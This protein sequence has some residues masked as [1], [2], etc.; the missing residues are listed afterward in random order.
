MAK[1]TG[2]FRRWHSDR[3]TSMEATNRVLAPLLGSALVLGLVAC[4]GKQTRNQAPPPAPVQAA[5]QAPKPAEVD[6]PDLSTAA[7][8]LAGF[9]RTPVANARGRKPDDPLNDYLAYLLSSKA[10]AP[11]AAFK[12]LDQDPDLHEVALKV[13]GILKTGQAKEAKDAQIRDLV[14]A[15]TRKRSRDQG[16]ELAQ[17]IAAAALAKAPRNTWV[18][19]PFKVDV[20]WVDAK[21]LLWVGLDDA[22]HRWG[23]SAPCKA[24][25]DSPD[26]DAL[27]RAIVNQSGEFMDTVSQIFLENLWVTTDY[28]TADPINQLKKSKGL[29]L[30]FMNFNGFWKA[31]RVALLNAATQEVVLEITKDNLAPPQRAGKAAVL[32]F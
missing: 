29:K 16:L 4:H 13:P 6:L 22:G 23:R 20:N 31:G 1:A 5:P 28:A 26:R 9:E 27:E 2:P 24:N 14:A 21:G 32:T 18:V 11:G 3:G 10:E 30:A 12:A 7:F 25:Y 17:S 15:V 8:V 19:Y